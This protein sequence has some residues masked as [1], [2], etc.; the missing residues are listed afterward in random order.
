MAG[1]SRLGRYFLPTRC[2]TSLELVGITT[3]R[4]LDATNLAFLKSVHGFGRAGLKE[5]KRVRG[6]VAAERQANIPSKTPATGN[7]DWMNEGMKARKKVTLLSEAPPQKFFHSPKQGAP[8]PSTDPDLLYWT[9]L[10][11]NVAEFIDNACVNGAYNMSI[12][13]PYTHE[14]FIS[15]CIQQ[16]MLIDPYKAGKHEGGGSMMLSDW[17]QGQ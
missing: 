2:L 6:I 4:Q 15:F 14:H 1:D 17:Q 12:P 10:R 13:P 5:V 11:P 7:L 16:Q 8:P 9:I 3:E